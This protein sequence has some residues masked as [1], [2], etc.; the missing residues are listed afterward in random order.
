MLNSGKSTDRNKGSLLLEQLTAGRDSDLLA[1]IRSAALDSLIEMA[2]WR[3]PNHAGFA[4]MVLGRVA[5]LPEDRLKE[6]AW[7]GPVDAIIEA[8]RR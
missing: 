3:R 4:R 5:G 2:S 6:L 7:N 1:K 8:A